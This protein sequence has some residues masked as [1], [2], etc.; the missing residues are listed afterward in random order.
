[1]MN[2]KYIM[3]VSSYKN[4]DGDDKSFWM[5]VGELFEAN[6]KTY[7]K[8]YLNPETLYHVF[9]ADRDADGGEKQPF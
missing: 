8:L 2:K 3:S 6:G 5:R 1:M 4:K 9:D 7:V